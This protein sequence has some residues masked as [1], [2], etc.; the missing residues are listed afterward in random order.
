MTME[1]SPSNRMIERPSGAELEY[2]ALKEEVLR[3]LEGRQQLISITLTIAGAYL[4][5]GWTS[6]SSVALLLYP[7]L[8][9]LLSAAWAQN[10]L[11]IRRL[12]TYI[13]DNLEANLPGL[14]WENY[15][16]RTHFET[17]IAGWPV[18]VLAFGGVFLL[19]Q[20]LAVLL[21]FFQIQRLTI[22]EMILLAADILAMLGLLAMMDSVRKNT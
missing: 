5:V 17:Q 15:K 6:G 1:N 19:P 4:G 12:N 10:E 14:G 11:H 21:G 16:R 7:L 20:L 13:R 18:D 8:G 9:A 22:L 2:A 3:R